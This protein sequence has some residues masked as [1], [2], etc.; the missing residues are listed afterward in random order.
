MPKYKE[1][2]LKEHC[3]SISRF[4]PLVTN[5]VLTCESYMTIYQDFNT[6]EKIN[7]LIEGF[8]G[9]DGQ[10]DGKLVMQILID[11]IKRR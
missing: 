11:F 5:Y 1:E 4:L 3:S 7:T 8:Q 10:L 9:E 6:K 2:L